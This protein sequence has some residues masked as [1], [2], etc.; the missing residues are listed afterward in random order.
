MLTSRRGMILFIALQNFDSWFA[1]F[2][3]YSGE[4]AVYNFLSDTSFTINMM[5][6][7]SFGNHFLLL[8]IGLPE[9]LFSEY[10]LFYVARYFL[11]NQYDYIIGTTHFKI[12][13]FALVKSYINPQTTG[14]MEYRTKFIAVRDLTNDK[15]DVPV[16]YL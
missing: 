16:L 7:I 10:V 4:C 6:L 13:V 15:C 2:F 5:L 9:R 1:S 14:Y 12:R 8:Y 11:L 3:F